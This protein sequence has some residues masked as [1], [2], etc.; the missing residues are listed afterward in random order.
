MGCVGVRGF[1]GEGHEGERRRREGGEE[2]KGGGK[3]GG[4]E[5][6][7]THFVLVDGPCGVIRFFVA[8]VALEAERRVPEHVGVIRV[9]GSATSRV[10]SLTTTRFAT[11]VQVWVFG[12]FGSGGFGLLGL[13]DRVGTWSSRITSPPSLTFGHPLLVQG[14]HIAVHVGVGSLEP[15]GESACPAVCFKNC[16]LDFLRAGR[17]G[18]VEKGRGGGGR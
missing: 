1:N 5:C 7:R 2:E 15:R 17:G 10:A 18:G 8:V 4:E 16:V 11:D 3:G 13:H 9:L 12:I 6:T 14:S